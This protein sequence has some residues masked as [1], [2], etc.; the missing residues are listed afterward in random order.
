MNTWGTINDADR[1]SEN[2]IIL[3]SIGIS[4][5]II[6][7]ILGVFFPIYDWDIANWMSMSDD[8]FPINLEFYHPIL[9]HAIIPGILVGYFAN[10]TRISL[11][12]SHIIIS[13]LFSGLGLTFLMLLSYK[14]TKRLIPS[15]ILGIMFSFTRTFLLITLSGEN[16]LFGAFYIAIL[17]YFAWNVL[18]DKDLDRNELKVRY[19]VLSSFSAL[20]TLF[21]LQL[22]IIGIILPGIIVLYK[23]NT[24]FKEISKKREVK[25]LLVSLLLAY[26]AYIISMVIYFVSL[27]IMFDTREPVSLSLLFDF[28]KINVNTTEMFGSNTSWSFLFSGR[29][30]IDQLLIFMAGMVRA[31]YYNGLTF[32]GNFVTYSAFPFFV[33]SCIFYLNP[34][35]DLFFRT[36]DNSKK[37]YK[38]VLLVCE[39]LYAIYI[40]MYEAYSLE[41]WSPLII[42]LC[43]HNSL[44]IDFP[45]INYK[46]IDK[47]KKKIILIIG[48]FV[49][50]IITGLMVDQFIFRSNIFEPLLILIIL[51]ILNII[52]ALIFGALILAPEKLIKF[53]DKYEL[54]LIANLVL[55]LLAGFLVY[56]YFTSVILYLINCNASQA[57]WC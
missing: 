22:T 41:R 16:D 23:E 38:Q 54:S 2:S 15:I 8:S 47:I 1:T 57:G 30:F 45:L 50:G 25:N 44:I 3:V 13:C 31:F 48:V 40:F 7:L 19:I 32:A 26:L 51:S 36:T 46:N 10:L 6:Y 29:T 49:V 12:Y 14:I 21:H 53:F 9:P 17:L 5:M 56:I 52:T 42:M 27:S 43:W 28:L 35:L 11:Y 33:L 37:R 18:E 24:S 55:S 34:I 4:I 39:L 20:L